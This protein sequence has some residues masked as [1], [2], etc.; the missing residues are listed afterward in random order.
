MKYV[1][2]YCAKVA[3]RDWWQGPRGGK[4]D[5]KTQRYVGLVYASRSEL[6]EEWICSGCGQTVRNVV[7]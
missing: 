4:P 2:I 1:R 5:P 6:A 7:S 3:E